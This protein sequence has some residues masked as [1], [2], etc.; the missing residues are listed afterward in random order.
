MIVLLGIYL[1]IE[2]EKEMYMLQGIVI[3]GKH[4]KESVGDMRSK[5]TSV[6]NPWKCALCGGDVIHFNDDDRRVE[7]VITKRN[8]VVRF[9]TRCYEEML[10]KQREGF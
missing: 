4:H 1:I 5:R 9:H 8:T 3:I 7:E 10:R 2:M 6:I